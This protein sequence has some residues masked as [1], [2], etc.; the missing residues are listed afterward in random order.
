[1]SGLQIGPDLEKETRL[2]G[3]FGKSWRRKR[4]LCLV[5]LSDLA[6]LGEGNV[7]HWQILP[8]LEKEMC[9][10]VRF[11]QTWRRKRF[12]LADFAGV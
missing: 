12:S 10:G 4:V 8:E 5:S 11:G 3:R 7:S 9:A 6:R 1:M 2:I